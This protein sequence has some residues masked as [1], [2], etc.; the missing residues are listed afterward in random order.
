MKKSVLGAFIGL[1][2]VLSIDSLARV[3]IA[4]LENEEI[5]MFSYSGYPG[6]IWPIVLVA[7][8]GLSTFL[9]A[10]FTLSYGKLHKITGLFIFII[11]LTLLR[12][13]QTYL[14]MGTEELLYPVAGFV[15]SLLMTFP[16]WTLITPNQTTEMANDDPPVDLTHYHL[17]D[18]FESAHSDGTY[19]MISLSSYP[20]L[21]D[22]HHIL[23]HIALSSR[24]P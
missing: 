16:A 11:L 20:N 22:H 21:P 5:L 2:V 3:I 18:E 10:L 9:G 12:Y 14:L 1:S 8:A 19:K 17:P 4:V 7:V 13:S 23:I 6:I 24:R 15:L